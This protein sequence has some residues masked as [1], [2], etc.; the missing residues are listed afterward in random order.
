MDGV[1]SEQA[2]EEPQPGDHLIELV[3][4]KADELRAAGLIPAE[5]EAR[6]D[7]HAGKMSP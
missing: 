3:R 5:L 7:A 2:T 1:P 6:L 4:R